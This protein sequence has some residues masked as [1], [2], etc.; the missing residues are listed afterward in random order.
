MG[1]WDFAVRGFALL[2]T[3]RADVAGCDRGV[4]ALA[5]DSLAGRVIHAMSLAIRRAWTASRGRKVVQQLTAVIPSSEV[6][7]WRLRGWIVAVV[8]ATA[9]AFGRLTSDSTSPLISMTPALLVVAGAFVMAC[10]APLAR[11]A[12]DRRRRTSASSTQ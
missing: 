2:S 3:P 11:A 5:R 4:E 12:A 8:G 7:V 1:W 6:A 10:A 9:L